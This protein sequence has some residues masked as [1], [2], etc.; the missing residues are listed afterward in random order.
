MTRTGKTITW[1]IVLVI[2]VLAIVWIGKKPATDE[3]VLNEGPIK[4]GFI[5]PLTGDTAGLGTVSRSAVELAV[6]EVNSLGGVNGRMLEVIYEDG[7]CT[8]SVATNAGQKLINVDK[9]TAIIGGLC[10]GET[11]SFASQ[12]MQNKIPVIS[13]CSSAPALSNTGK[14]FFRTYPS[15]AYQGQF[16]AEYAYNTLG[17]RKVAVIY[18]ISDWGTGIKDVFTK[19]FTELGGTVVATE[20]A[21]QETRDYRTQVAK[22]KSS[23]YDLVYVPVYVDGG[24]VLTKQLKDAGIPANKILGSETFNDPKFLKE[25]NG[26]ADG[27]IITASENSISDE[28]KQKMIAKTGGVDVPICSPQAYD[29]TNILA[30]ALKE[31]GT[32]PDLLQEAIRGMNY[33][34]E[35]GAIS[36]DQNGDPKTANYVISKINKG[37]LEKVE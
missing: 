33:N 15:D 31:I 37:A 34:G 12:A 20:G 7:Q 22:I 29:A 6:E 36:F 28:F 17:A 24:I 35:S 9:V 2:I 23:G 21:A 11:S 14:Y 13:Y 4:I 27:I 18:H 26:I 1:I 5:G 16:A 32:D 10:S 3:N 25:T 8:P 19:R 30:N